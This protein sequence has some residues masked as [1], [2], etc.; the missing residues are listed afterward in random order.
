[1]TTVD[2]FYFGS[3]YAG[4]GFVFCRKSGKKG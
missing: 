2:A 1:M 4:L 3:G